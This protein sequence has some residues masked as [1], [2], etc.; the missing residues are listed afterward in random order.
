MTT[1][2]RKVAL[3]AS[4]AGVLLWAWIA[5]GQQPRRIDDAVLRNAGKTGQEWLSYGLTPGE[6]RY[7]P[8][9]Q[10]DGTNVSRLGLTWSYEIGPG[11]GGQEPGAG[12]HRLLP[13][14]GVKHAE[15][16]VI[17]VAVPHQ[18]FA[19]EADAVDRRH[20]AEANLARIGVV[21]Q[22]GVKAGG[23]NAAV[24]EAD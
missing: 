14:L 17:G 12:A 15:E 3:R 24:V 1:N 19:R 7:S 10:I 23:A 18:D 16:R 8:L 9:K 6:T 11:G 13:L 2:A 4:I 21:E 5:P 20:V 22:R